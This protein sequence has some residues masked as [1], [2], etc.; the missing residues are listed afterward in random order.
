M[1]YKEY[2]ARLWGFG[3]CSDSDEEFQC[4]HLAV[5]ER[6]VSFDGYG[7]I[8]ECNEFIDEWIEKRRFPPE[9]N[10]VGIATRA[11]VFAYTKGRS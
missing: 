5:N 2:R 10:R 3:P 9:I 7:T 6:E 11:V 4:W 1:E 8:H